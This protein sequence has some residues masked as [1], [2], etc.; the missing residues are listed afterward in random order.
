MKTST[1][2]VVMHIITVAV[3]S[4]LLV[5]QGQIDDEEW[6]D[7]HDML[8]YDASSKTMR[9]PAQPAELN[10]YPNVPTKR[11]EYSQDLD[12]ME[13]RECNN[14]VEGLQREIEEYKKKI[15]QVAQQPSSNPVFKRFL[16]KLLKEIEKVGLP[17]DLND[18]HYDAK[19][20]L[21][22]QAVTEIRKLL[23]GMDTWRTG[24]LDNAL[25][26]IL[27]DLKPHDYEAW[28][29]HF[30]D[31]F[32]VEIDTV[33]KV[34]VWVLIIVVI[35]CSELWSTVSWFVQFKR[36]FA[37]CF[38]ISL[39]WNWFYLYKIAFAEHQN[40]MVKMEGVD[41]KCT[42]RKKIDWWDNL[43]DWYRGAMTLQD[44][45]CKMYYEVL[46]VNPILLVPP[47]KAITMTITTFFTE[48]LKHIG[49]GIS[50]FLRALLKDLP[51]TLQI[52]VLLTIV[53]SILVF[54]YGSAQAAIQ[55]GITRPLR[56]G[57]PRDPSPPALDQP[58]PEAR[59]RGTDHNPL[60]GGD[61]PQCSPSPL[62]RRLGPAANQGAQDRTY[63][64]QRSPPHRPRKE[65]TRRHVETLRNGDW[66]YSE[67]KIIS[68][69]W[70]DFTDAEDTNPLTVEGN[71]DIQAEMQQEPV[72]VGFITEGNDSQEAKPSPVKAK[73]KPD[74]EDVASDSK[75]AADSMAE[76]LEYTGGRASPVH[77]TPTSGLG[78]EQHDKFLKRKPE[79]NFTLQTH[80][81]NAAS[82]AGFID[83]ESVSLAAHA[84]PK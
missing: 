67:D 63:V 6:L 82:V 49:Q 22:R 83:N 30:E 69:C 29:W 31:T 3:C 5:A 77:A 44:D 23:E 48:P 56:V 38:L 64:G 35:I 20:K 50:E 74:E 79:S 32:G 73:A 62:S 10:N 36:I 33:M 66:R 81:A 17:T 28:R 53:F 7:P 21:S 58:M 84:Q 55:H 80:P 76:H 1:G 13:V 26:Q 65:P 18:I 34:S 40:K 24:A 68:E 71:T 9:K 25:S 42:G 41:A 75:G 78:R 46:M 57:G 11:R 59:L 39:V 54:M 12:Q 27:V 52:P 47:T 61:A 43:K 16:T 19:V 45:P 4:L 14:K 60:A 8:N 51:V 2:A 70:D 37:I 15:T 72:E